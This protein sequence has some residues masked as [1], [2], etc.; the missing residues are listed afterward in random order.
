MDMKVLVVGGG[1]R[2]HA[3]TRALSCNSD[4]KI[5]SVM[6][7]KNP[8]I[9][10][11]SERVLLEKETN[12]E[13]V[14]PFA[15]NCGVDA[16][17]IGPEAPLEAGIVDRLEAAGI[18]SLGPTRAAA[19]I[20]TDKAFCR[21]L[22]E[23]HGIAGCPE[24]RVCRDPEEARR[25]IESYDGDLAVKPIGL[26]GGKGVRIMGEH[27]DVAGAVEY[28]REIGGSVVLEER[29][30]GEEFTLQAFVDGEHLIPMPLVQD[31]KRAYEGDVGPNT[32]GMGSYSL[33]DHM[34]PF[35][36]R[37]DYEKALRIMTDT[38]AA[39]RAEGT[40][41]RGIL[42]GQFMNTRE[43]PKV[44]E[45]NARFGDPEAMNVLSLLESDFAG[46]VGHIIEG[47]LAPS[48]V[49]FAKKAT[50]CKY[51]VP[52]GYPDAPR[53]NEPLTLGDYG[54]A[55]LYY[56]SVE[57]RDGTLHTLT[58]RTLAF[59]GRGETLEEAEAIAEKA[60]SSVSGS[61]F[62][63]RDIGTPEILE[64]RCQHMREIL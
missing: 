57:E 8:G 25:F 52:E 44:I 24:Y 42:Y 3:I 32:G 64:K 15:T 14:I 17:V 41:Y 12:I 23:R 46:I 22:M 28:A 49:R 27:V 34:L 26:T 11:L 35:V 54:D 43:G 45:F 53:A 56:A 59:V 36:S 21:R 10:R 31:H 6:A 1:G 9:A 50:V 37:R 13:K 4:T 62:H 61:V 7:R 51:L 55:L 40:P 47:D 33:A 16:A 19:R 30:V 39:M 63:R 5:F 29:L 18:P 58:S 60:A 20:E 38:V 2:E 48:H